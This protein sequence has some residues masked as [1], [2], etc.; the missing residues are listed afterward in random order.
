MKR[1]S[2]CLPLADVRKNFAEVVA[3]ARA[4]LRIRLT[5]HGKPVAW[6]IGQAD[7]DLLL[8]RTAAGRESRR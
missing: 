2:L 4:G 1:P 8:E 3:S 5:R 6:I 7:H